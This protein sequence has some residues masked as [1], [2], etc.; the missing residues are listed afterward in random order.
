VTPTNQFVPEL[1]NFLC[2]LFTTSL[3]E[4]KDCEGTQSIDAVLCE[5]TI[6]CVEFYDVTSATVELC[7]AYEEEERKFNE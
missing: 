1:I 6:F 7:K 3:I 5:L 2:G 4:V